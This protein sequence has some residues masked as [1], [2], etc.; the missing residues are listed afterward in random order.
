MVPIRGIVGPVSTN[1]SNPM[2]K[3][4]VPEPLLAIL[5][6]TVVSPECVKNL[7][8]HS[9]AESVVEN[10]ALVPSSGGTSTYLYASIMAQ[11][12]H[13]STCIPWLFKGLRGRP[14][15]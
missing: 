3:Y 8:G 4:I 10:K 9:M 13:S 15:Y 1:D 6:F 2:L 14:A 5:V 11:L 7:E 12:S